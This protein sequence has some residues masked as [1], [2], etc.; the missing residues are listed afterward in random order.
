MFIAPDPAQRAR[1]TYV[2]VDVIR[3]TTTLAV[4][5]GQGCRC[6]LVA[7][8][9]AAARAVAQ[10]DPGRYLLGGESG[11]VAPPGF[12]FGNS[13][14]EYAAADPTGREIVFA[15]TNGTRALRAC[16]GGYAIYAGSLR[17]ASAVARAAFA[18]AIE[19]RRQTPQVP[20]VSL[21]SPKASPE[22]SLGASEAALVDDDDGQSD[23]VVVCAGREGQPSYDDTLCAGYLIERIEAEAAARDLGVM[24]ESGAR[25]ARDACRYVMER[26][27]GLRAALGESDAGRA[28]RSVGLEADLDWCAAIDAT[29]VVPYVATV[30]AE[31]DLL[32]L[33]DVG[34]EE[35]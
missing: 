20:G 16:T 27:D 32:V 12:N 14:R 29:D 31:R 3:A 13:P 17:N 24:M 25:I 7:S 21:S 18:S 28:I 4:M 23:I 8:G 33:R 6:V 22:T 9:I 5:L 35:V 1:T 19:A 30:D 26:P 15:T 2:V 11:G 10:P 34:R